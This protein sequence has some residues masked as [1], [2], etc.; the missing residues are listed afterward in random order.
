MKT[1]TIVSS[2]VLEIDAVQVVEEIAEA[3]REIVLHR[4][5]RNGAVVGLSGGIDSSVTAAL[6]CA[7]PRKGPSAW[8]V[9]AGG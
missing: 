2:Q 5:R 1:I 4:L 9:D 7:G 6:L 8:T 3:I